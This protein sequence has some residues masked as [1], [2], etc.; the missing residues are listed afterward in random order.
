[1]GTAP[2]FIVET[3]HGTII[4]LPGVPRE[5]ERLVQDAVC[6]TCETDWA[7]RRW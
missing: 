4:A 2:G 5:M 3:E 1:V 7:P 6:H